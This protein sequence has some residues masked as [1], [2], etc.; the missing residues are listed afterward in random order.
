MMEF[1]RKFYLRREECAPDTSAQNT[2]RMGFHMQGVET[3]DF[4]DPEAISTFTD[5]GPDV[6]VAGYI[7]DVLIALQHMGI[8]PPVLLDYPDELKGFLGRA[9][10]EADFGIIRGMPEKWRAFVKPSRDHKLFTGLVYEG[11]KEQRRMLG[12][13]PDRTPVWVSSAMKFVSEYRTFILSNEILDCRRYK[14]DWSKAPD[15]SVV[16]AAVLA[17]SDTAPV[18]YCLD[19]GVTDTGETLLVE[20]N[21]GFAM[22]PYG[23]DPPRYACMIAARWREMANSADTLAAKRGSTP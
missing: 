19:F 10:S 8:K 5:L 3:V 1:P 4:T 2:I 14:G 15:R 17:M 23:L 9:V 13:V 6:G 16:E 22:G 21:D 12:Y 20:A 11:T 18:A 7:S